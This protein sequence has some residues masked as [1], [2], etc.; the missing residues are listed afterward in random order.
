M[1]RSDRVGDEMRKIIADLIQNE[2]KDPRMPALASVTEVSVSRDLSHANVFVS[3]M[4][5]EAAKARCLE[6]LTSASGFIRRESGRRIR[7][8]TMPELHFKIDD[9]IERGIRMT[10]LID[11]TLGEKKSHES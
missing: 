1:Q 11:E 3:V 8:R 9:S 6:A 2:I 10:R 5:D 7:L 4:G